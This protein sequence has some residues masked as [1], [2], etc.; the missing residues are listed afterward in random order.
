MYCYNILREILLQ[1]MLK[2]VEEASALNLQVRHIW[3]NILKRIALPFPFL[4][5]CAVFF[6]QDPNQHWPYLEASLYTWSAVA[7]SLAEEEECPILTQFLA[8]LPVIPYNNN[9]RVCPFSQF[10]N[11]LLS[12]WVT[13]ALLH[14]IENSL[15]I[16]SLCTQQITCF[17]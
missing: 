4:T 15:N 16:C 1:K 5:F 14:F 17:S 3:S 8:K 11:Y 6:L 2:H 7:E 10:I 12:K 13:W 9:M